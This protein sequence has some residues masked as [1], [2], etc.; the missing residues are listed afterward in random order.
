MQQPLNV[1]RHGR[2]RLIASALVFT[3]VC[4][5]AGDAQGA[6]EQHCN[7]KACGSDV[8]GNTACIPQGFPNDI[9]RHCISYNGICGSDLCDL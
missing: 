7:E 9:R 4:L 6:E 5:T 8:L 2:W 3:M 1:P